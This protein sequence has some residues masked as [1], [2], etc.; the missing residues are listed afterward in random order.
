[1]GIVHSVEP[2]NFT[3]IQGIER[4]VTDLW[5]TSRGGGNITTVRKF[6]ADSQLF[7]VSVANLKPNTDHKFFIDGADKTSLCK[8]I[9][10]ST[11]V[12]TA[13]R[14][15]ENGLLAFDY[16]YDAGINEATSDLE[17]QN[18]LVASVAGEKQFKVESTDGNSFAGGTIT[19]KS[20]I[21]AAE[22]GGTQSTKP[23]GD[24]VDTE[25]G[26]TDSASKTTGGG[27]AVF[28]QDPSSRFNTIVNL[29]EFVNINFGDNITI[30]SG[31]SDELPD[32]SGS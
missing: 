32:R 2:P 3:I 7:I 23:I 15:D 31:R 17:E 25:T 26:S 8:Q 18:K 16:Y 9:R 20:Y 28:V 22:V 12:A 4:D 10:I 19:I 13:L 11:D 24:K 1:M 29:N 21:V 30:T 6:V 27:G 14:S 5:N